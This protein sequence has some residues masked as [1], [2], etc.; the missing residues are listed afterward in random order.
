LRLSGSMMTFP[1]VRTKVSAKELRRERLLKSYRSLKS[2]ERTLLRLLAVIFEPVNHSTIFRCLQRS[3]IEPRG[4]RTTSLRALVPRLQSLFDLKLIDSGNQVN[5][6]IIEIVCREAMEPEETVDERQ[7]LARIEE[8]SSWAWEASVKD[9]CHQCEKRLSGPWLKT[10]RGPL[11]QECLGPVALS[12][13]SRE[14]VSGWSLDRW[15]ESLSGEGDLRSRLTALFRFK[16]ILPQISALDEA[17][18]KEMASLLLANLGLD[19]GHPADHTVR[20]AAAE[21][22]ILLDERVI[23]LVQ[24]FKFRHWHAFACAVRVAARMHPDRHEGLRRIL[25]RAQR[26]TNPEVR[27]ILALTLMASTEPWAMD[28]KVKLLKDREPSVRKL[29]NEG[30]LPGG[31]RAW[32][33]APSPVHVAEPK[34]PFGRLA[35]AVRDELPLTGAHFGA[36]SIYCRRVLRDLRIGVYLGDQALVRSAGHLLATQCTPQLP[37]TDPVAQICCNPFDPVWFGKQPHWLQV[38]AVRA[39]FGQAVTHLEPDGEVL[40]HVLD[41]NLPGRLESSERAELLQALCGRLLMAGRLREVQ[42]ILDENERHFLGEGLRGWMAL[43]RGDVARSLEL[44]D[45]DLKEL[46][47]L[48]G[49]KIVTFSGIEG[50]FHPLACIVQGDAGLLGRL[51]QIITWAE[52]RVPQGTSL[53]RAYLCIKGILH[54]LNME[55]DLARD[56]LKRVQ[57]ATDSLTVFLGALASFWLDGALDQDR[58]DQLSRLFMGAR[59]LGLNWLAMECAELLRLTEQDTPFRRNIVD[60]IAEETGMR[61]IIGSL[62]IEEPWKRS[63]KALVQ[64]AASTREEASPQGAKRRLIWLVNFREGRIDLQPLEQ[65]RNVRGEWTRGRPVAL[66]RFQKGTGLEP[67]SPH[68][69]AIRDS[70]VRDYIYY[71]AEYR[72]ERDKLLPSL[73]GHPLLFLEAAPDVSV[74]FVRGEPEVVVSQAGDHV[75]INFTHPVSDNHYFVVQETPTRFKVVQVTEN[76]RRIARILGERGLKVPASATE[77]ILTAIAGISALVTVHSSIEGTSGEVVAVE[78]QRQPVIHLLPAG[79]GLRMQIYVRP[80]GAGGPYLKPGIGAENV[81]AEI[82]GTRLQTRRDLKAEAQLADEV[83]TRC[84]SLAGLADMDRHWVIDSPNDCLQLLLDLKTL[85]D[86]G[87]VIIEWP[88]GEKLRVTREVSFQHLRMKIRGKTD[89]FEMSGELRLEDGLVVEM[90]RLIELIHTSDSRFVPLSEGQ[91][92]ALSQELHRRLKDLESF[93]DRRSKELRVHPLASLALGDLTDRIEQLDAD[94]QW[95]MRVESLRNAEQVFPEVPSTLKAKLREYQVEGFRWLARLASLGMGACLADDMGLGKTIQAL[96]VILSRA[97]QGPTLVVA[98]TSVCM[99]WVNEAG[100]FAPTLSV[101][102]FGGPHRESLVRNLGPHDILVCSYGLLQQEIELLSSVDWN[103]IVLDEAQAIKNMATKRSQAAMSLKGGFKLITT[104]TP[105]EN[106]LGEFYTLFNFINPGLLG[107]QK[108]FNERFAVPIER[109]NDRDA[110]R[111]LKKLIQPFILRR[112]K[113]QVLEELPPR[114]EVIL[115]VEMS[116]EEAAFYEA[117][118]RKALEQLEE[119][120]SP[121]VQKHIRILAEITRLRQAACNP[122]LV[123]PQT[124]LPSSKLQVFGEIVG[125]LLESKHKALVFSQFVGHLGLIREYLDRR[126]IDY[127]Y[128][129]GSTPPRERQQQVEAFQEGRGE[130]FLISLKAGGLGLNLTAADYVIHMDPWWNPA[131]EDQ[132]SDRA[133]RIGQRHPVTVYRLVTRHTIEEKIVKLHRDK[134]DLASGLLDGSDISGKITVEELLQLIREDAPNSA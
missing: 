8:R 5:R 86:E 95:T 60:R 121:A 94:P 103:T 13:F 113:S 88:E 24:S 42:A 69:Q 20:E 16:E 98:P 118:R 41:S 134:R 90:K 4:E 44:Y 99:N 100:R 126:G 77:D 25:E 58:V 23:P 129:D 67:L 123:M 30:V 110:R 119:D 12:A 52:S 87:R 108:R 26:H 82:E 109:N 35:R 17:G 61:S 80:F 48:T 84:S 34:T 131:V 28:L 49:R 66:A 76:H 68:D 107:S 54:V 51:G 29:A 1:V 92:L 6:G 93:A 27:R 116:P 73:V 112:V 102:V 125:E 3:E 81:L 96:G 65:K 38:Q 62:N 9:R 18:W 115:Q 63:L 133:H 43:L 114:T 97:G 32:G 57:G 10:L 111:R 37:M 128:L 53:S 89:W 130:L 40:C 85:Q 39:I 45:A 14:D 79:L 78:A 75:E 22:V 117:L 83:E 74:Q 122:R 91:Y 124:T 7:L 33:G 104:G 47:R 21:A 31:F 19:R 11:C 55:P 101:Q 70:L 106:H 105:I 127:R 50:V 36:R 132:A 72:F 15:R 46:R 64:V 56:S 120:D 2:A 59:R 71:G